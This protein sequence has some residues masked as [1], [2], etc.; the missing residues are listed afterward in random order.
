MPEDKTKRVLKLLLRF[1][2]TAALLYLVF[3]RIDL[4]RLTRSIRNT[5]Y[6]LLIIVWA[7]AVLACWVRS[8]KMRLI[9]KKQRCDLATGKIFAASSVMTLYGLVL[10][11]LLSTGV[12]WYIL[13]QHTHKGSSVLSSMFYNQA[14][15]ITV[16]LLTGLAAIIIASPPSYPMLPAVAA[17]LLA[18]IVLAWMLMLNT[19]TNK[20]IRPAVEYLL[21]PFP[22]KIQDT[23]ERMFGQLKTFQKTGLKFHLKILAVNLL[24]TILGFTS[25]VFAARAAAIYVP[26]MALVWQASVVYVLGRV[27]IS[28]ANLGVREFTLV[29]FLALYGIEAP[30]AILLSMIV[31]SRTILLAAIGAAFQITWAIRSKRPAS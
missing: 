7:L 22:Q 28:I 3:S 27:P 8:V 5:N 12:K 26:A 16:K 29:E 11:G 14:T 15:D 24:D 21:R 1:S 9:L 18:L 20:K 31:F 19:W 17:V 23:A 13:K 4:A 10:P 2:V 25:F 30:T 6:S